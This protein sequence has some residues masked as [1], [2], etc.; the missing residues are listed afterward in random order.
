[1]HKG[2]IKIALTPEAITAIESNPQIMAT[3]KTVAAN[4]MHKM[5]GIIGAFDIETFDSYNKRFNE[6]IN[7]EFGTIE[8]P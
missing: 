7:E 5:G 2:R 6:A 4:N 3:T 8:K 1:M